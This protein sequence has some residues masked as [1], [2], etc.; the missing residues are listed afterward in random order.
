[1]KI[2]TTRFGAIDIQEEQVI[3][4]PSGLIGFPCHKR[5]ILLEHK[6]GSPFIWF[7]SVDDEALAFVLI[8]PLLF[9][10]EYEIQINRED[11]KSLELSDSCDGLQTLAIVNIKPGDPLE[12]T[13]NLLGPLV[14]NSKKKLAKQIILYQYPYSTRTPIPTVKN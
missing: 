14:I 12:I 2:P 6:K 13:A 4:V 9:Q 11:R 3:Y 7:Q 5:Y 10:P 1:M 8:D